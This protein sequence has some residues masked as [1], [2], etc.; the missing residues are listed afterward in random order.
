MRYKQSF[1]NELL[2]IEKN[3]RN[4]EHM[5]LAHDGERIANALKTSRETIKNVIDIVI[6]CKKF[7]Y[8]GEKI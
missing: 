2:E 6:D 4:S 1:L 3:I 5:M 8:D 7:T